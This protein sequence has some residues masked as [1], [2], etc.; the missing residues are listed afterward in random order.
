MPRANHAFEKAGQTRLRQKSVATVGELFRQVAYYRARAADI[1][2]IAEDQGRP[3]SGYELDAIDHCLGIVR[4]I[5][6]KCMDFQF[7]KL[8]AIE[9]SPNEALLTAALQRISMAMALPE[10]DARELE[11]GPL[12]LEEGTSYATDSPEDGQGDGDS[13][14]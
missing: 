2:A 9:I 7:P 3:L 13:P 5:L 1:E 14:T 11:A 8:A 6:F 4:S 12:R 10:G